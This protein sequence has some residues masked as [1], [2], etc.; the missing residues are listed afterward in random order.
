MIYLPF[1]SR[2]CKSSFIFDLLGC[3]PWDIIY[4]VSLFLT[5]LISLV[6]VGCEFYSVVNISTVCSCFYLMISKTGL[7]QQGGSKSPIVD[8]LNTISE[9]RRILSG[10]GKGHPCELSV[11]EDSEAYSCG[12]LLYA[13]SSLYILLPGHDV[14]CIN[15]R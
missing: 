5:T 3:F 13:H 15:G 6:N 14:A 9:G 4:K 1:E 8:S 11:H 2:Y 12:A 7:W 10:F